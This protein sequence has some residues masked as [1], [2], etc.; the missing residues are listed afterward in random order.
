MLNVIGE[1]P[2]EELE[3]ELGD[4]VPFKFQCHKNR[5][6]PIYWRTGDLE[7]TLLE[8]EINSSNGQVVGAS[9][10]LAGVVKKG[11]PALQ[12]PENSHAGLP[13]VCTSNWS[14]D[15]FWDEIKPFDV[16]IDES[17][18]LVMLSNNT[19]GKILVAGNVTFGICTDGSLSWMLVSDLDPNRLAE[20]AEQ[21]Q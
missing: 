10:L 1:T 5:G 21:R 14:D 19:A 7:S 17:R 13:I 11:L 2:C 15:R 6:L 12:F 9:L 3:T 4:Y 16:F 20:L 8:V 18:L